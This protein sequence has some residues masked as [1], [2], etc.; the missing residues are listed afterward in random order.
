MIEDFWAEGG[1]WTTEGNTCQDGYVWNDNYTSDYNDRE[2]VVWRSGSDYE[3][4]AFVYLFGSPRHTG[5]ATYSTAGTDLIFVVFKDDSSWFPS[6]AEKKKGDQ[7]SSDFESNV[8]IDGWKEISYTV[9]VYDKSALNTEIQKALAFKNAFANI[10][11]HVTAGDWAAFTTAL[12]EAQSL[13]TTRAVDQSALDAAQEKLATAASALEFNV[14]ETT[15]NAAIVAADEKL[16]EDGLA[17]NYTASSITALQEALAAAK[18]YETPIR[19]NPYPNNSTAGEFNAKATELTSEQADV[20]ALA[21]ALNEALDALLG[22]AD[23]SAYEQDLQNNPVTGECYS[24]DTWSNYNVAKAAVEN[25]RA[26]ANVSVNRQD[27]VNAAIEAYIAARKALKEQHTFTGEYTT[28]KEATC[29]KSGLKTRQCS[30]CTAVEEVEIPPLGHE[31]GDVVN[32][33]AGNCTEKAYIEYQCTRCQ[34][35][36]RVE[37]EVNPDVHNWDAGVENPVHN[38]TNTGVLTKT[39]TVCG[40]TT[41]ETIPAEDNKKEQT[42]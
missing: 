12:S 14:D 4:N 8:V 41:T 10:S 33:F 29:T 17:N 6:T 28:V 5:T 15:L 40:T 37:G 13:L 30:K 32:Q 20:D 25:L 31:Q 18:A 7:N 3:H 19:W 22:R 34:V 36:Y 35:T 38:C 24:A 23:F 26:D 39:C 1:L 11:D 21:A 9:T 42:A 2:A 27:E 16:A